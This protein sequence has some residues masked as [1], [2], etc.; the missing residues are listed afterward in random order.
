MTGDELKDWRDRTSL[1]QTQAAKLLG[2]TPEA[3]AELEKLGQVKIDHPQFGPLKHLI[4]ALDR[5]TAVQMDAVFDLDMTAEFL[6]AWRKRM[7]WDQDQAANAL[8]IGKSTLAKHEISKGLVPRYLV[9]ACIGIESL[10][11]K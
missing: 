2:V 8:G 6:K 1:N 11:K 3:Y 10:Y 5:Q 4:K 9:L 7:G